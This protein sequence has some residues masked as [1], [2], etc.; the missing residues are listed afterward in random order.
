MICPIAPIAAA[1]AVIGGVHTLFVQDRAH[2]RTAWLVFGVLLAGWA[3]YGVGGRVPLARIGLEVTSVAAILAGGW[4]AWWLARHR[5]VRSPI[6]ARMAPWAR[7]FA[8]WLRAP[9]VLATNVW[10]AAMLTAEWRGRAH[11]DRLEYAAVFVAILG[12]VWLHAW[13]LSRARRSRHAA[14]ESY[15]SCATP[16]CPLVNTAASA[17]QPEPGAR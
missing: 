3:A 4:R 13:R 11:F 15:A 9:A 17:Q 8:S 14:L 10:L 6:V 5:G 16:G 12:A 2:R 1:G 7:V